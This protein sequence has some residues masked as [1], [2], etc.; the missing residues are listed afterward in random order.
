MASGRWRSKFTPNGNRDDRTSN[1]L[2][3]STPTAGLWLWPGQS[4]R[5]VVTRRLLG[6]CREPR[7]DEQDPIVR[8]R[9]EDILAYQGRL[10]GSPIFIGDHKQNPDL[11]QHRSARPKAP[12]APVRLTKHLRS[13]PKFLGQT[14]FDFDSQPDENGCPSASNIVPEEKK[15]GSNEKNSFDSRRRNSQPAA[16]WPG[17]CH[18][19]S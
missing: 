16:A 18:S 7:W 1:S 6:G 5:P 2:S 19:P 11:Q 9:C 8:I 15:G 14:A 3:K 10:S 17:L 12:Q 4:S 13:H